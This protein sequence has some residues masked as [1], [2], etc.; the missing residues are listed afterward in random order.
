MKN[1]LKPLIRPIAVSRCDLDVGILL[2]DPPLP[3]PGPFPFGHEFI[4]VVT[5]VGDEVLKI[6]VGQ[7]VVVPFQISC[8]SCSRCQKGF[9]GY[10]HIDPHHA[11]FGIGQGS[12]KYGGG[13]SDL[14]K[15]PYA[16][17]MLVPVPSSVSPLSVA[18]C[19]DN[20][21]DAWRA[22]GPLLSQNSKQSV[23]VV[24]GGCFSIGL[25]TVAT[26]KALGAPQVVYLDKNKER[27]EIAEKL[28]AVCVEG[29]PDQPKDYFNIT[30]DASMNAA[31]LKYAIKSTEPGGVCTSASIYP[32][33]FPFPFLSLYFAG[34]TFK[35]GFVNSRNDIPNVL[36]LVEK[37]LLKPE[38]ITT[39]VAPWENAIE[40]LFE[41]TTKVIVVRD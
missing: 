28:G 9:T 26:A 7:K 34:I 11:F 1:R 32:N 41:K 38:Q 25:Y 40:A 4:G 12:Q 30:V 6:K 24:G 5:K 20:L 39:K 23:L 35:S 15:I 2:G 10:C 22:V 14:V 13:F 33:D 27:L 16:D 19:S 37:G 8:G 31:G 36:S 18:S 17:A 29:L 21:V 3:G